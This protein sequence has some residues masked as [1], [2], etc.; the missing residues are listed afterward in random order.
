MKKIYKDRKTISV[1]KVAMMVTVV[2]MALFNQALWHEVVRLSVDSSTTSWLFPISLFVFL[3]LAINAILTLLA[4]PGLFKPLAVALIIIAASASYFMDT[5]GVMIDR[6]M[7]RNVL[8]TD[9]REAGDL[10]SIGMFVHLA[11]WGGIPAFLVIRQPI[12]YQPFF[13]AGKKK[14]VIIT[15]SF[16]V[17]AAIVISGFKQYSVFFRNNRHVRHLIAPVNVI[18]A[19]TTLLKRMHFNAPKEFEKI[20]LDAKAGSI[21]QNSGKRSLF[22]MV[23]GETARADHFSLQGYERETN[24]KLKSAGGIYFSNVS[25]CGTAT[26]TSLPCM[27]SVNSKDDFSPGEAKYREGLLDVMQR[28]GVRVWWLNNNSGCKGI[29]DRV[30]SEDL[31]HKEIPGLCNDDGCFDKILEKRLDKILESETG[32]IFVVLHQQ[33]SHGPAYYK[34][35]PKEF[36]RFTPTCDKAQIETCPQQDIINTYDNTLL[37]TDSVVADLITML[38]GHSDRFDSALL[39]ISDHGESLGEGGIYLHGLPYSIAPSAQTH[40]PMYMWLSKAF[41]QSMQLE[42]QCLS[43]TKNNSYSHDNLFH[44]MLGIMDIKTSSYN[45][46]LDMFKHCRK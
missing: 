7:I 5:F 3:L 18:Y 30:E 42:S 20:G 35:Y 10:L 28:A 44:T 38:K 15:L 36:R 2:I 41:S 11:L 16:V 17:M 13:S 6:D 22:V 39:Y 46:E 32:P 29:C 12:H 27:F 23:V 40:V 43:E 8:E 1:H 9:V 25:S 19:T 45:Q 14:S 31:S 34:R 33:G 4:W 26:A 21:L 37:Y 24:P